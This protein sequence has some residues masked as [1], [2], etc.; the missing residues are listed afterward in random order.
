[1]KDASFVCVFTIFT[2][3]LDVCFSKCNV[4]LNTELLVQHMWDCNLQI[5]QFDIVGL[6][7]CPQI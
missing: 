2:L 3:L 7:I 6:L 1:M 4:M 5:N